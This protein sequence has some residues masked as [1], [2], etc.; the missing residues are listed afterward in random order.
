MWTQVRG[1]SEIPV[2]TVQQKARG[3]C[4]DFNVVDVSPVVPCAELEGEI[5]L[6][7]I[8]AIGSTG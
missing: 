3:D 8:M 4:T 7:W 5:F 2:D 6:W 1:L